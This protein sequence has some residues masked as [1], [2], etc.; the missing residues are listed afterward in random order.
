MDNEEIADSELQEFCRWY[1]DHYCRNE[2]FECAMITC[3]CGYFHTYPR[4]AKVIV[5]R[6][7]SL[8][9]ISQKRNKVYLK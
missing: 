9:L 7:K 8:D 2:S 4:H 3:L 1:K 5:Y 6:L